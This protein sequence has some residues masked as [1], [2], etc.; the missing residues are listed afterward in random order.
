MSKRINRGIASQFWDIKEPD[1]EPPELNIEIVKEFPEKIYKRA[2]KVLAW[3]FKV[4]PKKLTL[5]GFPMESGGNFTHIIDKMYVTINELGMMEEILAHNYSYAYKLK[6]EFSATRLSYLLQILKY[7]GDCY[8][9]ADNLKEHIAGMAEEQGLTDLA[10][11]E[12]RMM[13]KIK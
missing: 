10:G 8:F 9:D 11:Y 4:G 5:C 6:L 3:A 13:E 12:K 1:I 2:E 7:D